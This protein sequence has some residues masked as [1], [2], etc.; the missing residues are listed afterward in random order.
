MPEEAQ[1]F[2]VGAFQ[3]LL[4]SSIAGHGALV[5]LGLLG[6]G[7]L[8]LV[9]ALVASVTEPVGGEGG[10]DDADGCEASAG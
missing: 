2:E 1:Q 6:S 4:T 9:S 3:P 8:M 7:L 5:L 10:Q